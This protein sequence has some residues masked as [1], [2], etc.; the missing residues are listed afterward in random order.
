MISSHMHSILYLTNSS[1]L[2]LLL[3][4]TTQW[5]SLTSEMNSWIMKCYLTNKMLLYLMQKTSL[6]SPTSLD[7]IR[8]L[9][10]IRCSTHPNFNQETSLP[11]MLMEHLILIP[12][13]LKS[14]MV[15]L[16]IMVHIFHAKFVARPTIKPLTVIIAWINPTKE[17]ILQLNL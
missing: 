1:H 11:N 10:T 5:V 9:P 7:L 6:C 12:N 4:E 3:L 16:S 8:F 13:L 14:I 15:P 2:S 17:D